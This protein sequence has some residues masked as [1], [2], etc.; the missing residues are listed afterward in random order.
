MSTGKMMSL[1]ILPHSLFRVTIHH[2][3][4]HICKLSGMMKDFSTLLTEIQFLSSMISVMSVKGNGVTRSFP[5]CHHTN[6]ALQSEFFNVSKWNRNTL[7]FSLLAYIHKHFSKKPKIKNGWWPGSRCRPSVQM[8][9]EKKE[10]IL[11][12]SLAF[13]LINIIYLYILEHFLRFLPR[14]GS[15]C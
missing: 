12:H 13:P 5:H 14:L 1:E 6:V 11:E 15:V 8:Q 9:V 4:F 10:W 7:K 2:E 3:L